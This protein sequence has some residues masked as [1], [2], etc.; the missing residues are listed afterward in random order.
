MYRSTTEGGLP[1]EEVTWTYKAAGEKL[2]MSRKSWEST[3]VIEANSCTCYTTCRYDI[4]ISECIIITGFDAPTS[5]G[6]YRVPAAIDGKVVVGV[7]MSDAV[8]GAC[9]FNDEDIVSTVK[10][11]YL[12]PELL[13]VE[14]DTI[15]LCTSIEALY[16]SSHCLWLEPEAVP[17]PI[18]W[19]W[20]IY[21]QGGCGMLCA[22]DNAGLYL[23]DYC[24]FIDYKDG[25]YTR[26]GADYYHG[27]NW[28]ISDFALSELYGR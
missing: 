10:R 16:V 24:N 3:D 9:H 27:A 8:D 22:K 14:R 20:Y 12:P 17:D 28:Q 18:A 15:N 19:E 2:H 26:W 11:V 1:I 13:L 7:D 23:R 5:N 4:P 21:S 25:Y 6:I